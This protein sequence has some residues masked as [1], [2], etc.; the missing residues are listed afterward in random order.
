MQSIWQKE[1]WSERR[2][3][4]DGKWQVEKEIIKNISQFL[5]RQIEIKIQFQ[6]RIF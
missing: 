3:I 5:G 6:L 4:L 1:H 2:R